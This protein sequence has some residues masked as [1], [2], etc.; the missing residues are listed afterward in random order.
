MPRLLVVDDLPEIC[1]VIAAYLREQG[2]VVETANHGAQARHA[3]E[4]GDYDA[5]IVDLVLP[6]SSGLALAQI[7]SAR[8]IPILLISGGPSTLGNM[9]GHAPH[10]FLQK[11]FHLA[12]LESAIH[13][14]LSA[15]ASGSGDVPRAPAG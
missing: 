14:L 15:G 5:A 3:L 7:A 6:G 1:D 9:N 4:G 12:E 13:V 8:A 11:P 2:H 10:L